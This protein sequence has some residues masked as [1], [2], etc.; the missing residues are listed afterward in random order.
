M[1]KI[2]DTFEPI[3]P[4]SGD[5]KSDDPRNPEK[6]RVSLLQCIQDATTT[7][8]C[9]QLLFDF[10]IANAAASP[11]IFSDLQ[12]L[13]KISQHTTRTECALTAAGRAEFQ[14]RKLR[15]Q[16]AVLKKW[17]GATDIDPNTIHAGELGAALSTVDGLLA[18]K[19]DAILRSP[20]GS[21]IEAL[22]R[23]KGASRDKITK[24]V[25]GEAVTVSVGGSE[26]RQFAGLPDGHR[27]AVLQQIVV[28]CG[29]KTALGAAQAANKGRAERIILELS[30]VG[31]SSAGLAQFANPPG[32]SQFYQRLFALISQ[33]IGT[34]FDAVK[35]LFQGS[36]I[37]FND[38][39]L[40]LK[41]ALHRYQMFLEQSLGVRA[42]N[43]AIANAYNPDDILDRL[44]RD[45]IGEVEYAFDLMPFKLQ[46]PAFQRVQLHPLDI[47]DVLA[48][49]RGDFAVGATRDSANRP[50]ID[51]ST[52]GTIE[53]IRAHEA[54]FFIDVAQP[55]IVRG[56]NRSVNFAN[57]SVTAHGIETTYNRK[58]DGERRAFK[59][60][61]TEGWGDFEFS[62]RFNWFALYS[63]RTDTTQSCD[64]LWYAT[65]RGGHGIG[66]ADAVEE[67]DYVWSYRGPAYFSRL[68]ELLGLDPARDL[69]VLAPPPENYTKIQPGAADAKGSAFGE[70]TTV[71]I[72]DARFVRCNG[73]GNPVGFGKPSST[74]LDSK[75]NAINLFFGFDYY[76]KIQD[77]DLVL[78]SGD[79]PHRPNK[80]DMTPENGEVGVSPPIDFRST[81]NL[82][83]FFS[84]KSS[85]AV[86]KNKGNELFSNPAPRL[87]AGAVMADI[88]N[89]FKY[90]AQ[91]RPGYL[92]ATEFTDVVI[93]SDADARTDWQQLR[94]T[95]AIALRV[96]EEWCHLRGHGDNGQERVGNFVAGSFHCNTEQLAIESGQRLTTYNYQ[97]GTFILK[98]TAYL[99]DNTAM[100]ATENHYTLRTD[101][102]YDE[103][104][105]GINKK[106]WTSVKRDTAPS[107]TELRRLAQTAPVAAFI[108][109][110]VYQNVG[111]LSAPRYS[112]LLDYLFEGQSEFFDQNQY[113]ILNAYVRFLL[114]GPKVFEEWYHE[115]VAEL[116][117]LAA[118]AE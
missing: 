92:S 6:Y 40:V 3:T 35:Q 113:R 107:E 43:A 59:S 99:L 55:L 45:L 28:G 110:K 47:V 49:T 8:S 22:R 64:L 80:N 60:K 114:Q 10:V 102:Q 30:K 112:K 26:E 73:P 44:I 4:G 82:Q 115:K 41:P 57:F 94:N 84:H 61:I 96:D 67:T 86:I 91:V 58:V 19:R 72:G 32:N 2:R 103:M 16:I 105:Y 56:A 25:F 52:V 23:V 39:T 50:L 7:A 68:G 18:A 66:R 101:S 65:S 54:L 29:R 34:Q 104:A 63:F 106:R 109:Y 13:E 21:L 38:Q 108:R 46:A 90:R 37:V 33:S 87:Q 24:W 31:L 111:T 116:P 12:Y 51:L 42:L 81:K 71:Q 62:L 88:Y 118:D 17:G 83:T 97:A 100:D 11:F 76:R 74:P 89:N 79:S 117:P 36:S 98:S 27:L 9:Y 48:P 14:R 69:G 20:D 77:E 53:F 85:R 75:T 5:S 70:Y 1:P 95:D 15:E 93:A 78:K